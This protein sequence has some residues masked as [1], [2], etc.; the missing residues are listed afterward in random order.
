MI[1]A[2]DAYQNCLAMVSPSLVDSDPLRADILQ[3]SSRI[4]AV[5]RQRG[6]A[7]RRSEGDLTALITPIDEQGRPGETRRV[8]L[9]QLNERGLA[10]EHHVPLR[11]RRALVTVDDAKVGCFT[12]EVDLSWCQYQPGGRYTSG[13]RFVH[14]WRRPA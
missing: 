5:L 12:A 13:G 1:P 8:R 14:P 11:D 3:L 6:C 4:R 7:D 10:V 2:R 9:A